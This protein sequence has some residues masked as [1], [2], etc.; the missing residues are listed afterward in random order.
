MCVNVCMCV[1]ASRA[2]GEA[3]TR[4]GK[5]RRHWTC[6]EV[7]DGLIYNNAYIAPVAVFDSFSCGPMLRYGI[8]KPESVVIEKVLIM[9]MMS[10]FTNLFVKFVLC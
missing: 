3:T 4:G 2:G 8:E 6:S 1:E 7:S 9:M 10:K 5:E